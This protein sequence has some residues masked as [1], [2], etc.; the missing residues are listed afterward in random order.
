MSSEWISV[1]D[2]LPNEYGTYLCQ[3]DDGTI[4]TLLFNDRQISGL[5]WG[6]KN[7]YVRYWQPLPE[8]AEEDA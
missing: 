4:E 1:L 6:T 2:D 7:S 5:G 3:F 8:P